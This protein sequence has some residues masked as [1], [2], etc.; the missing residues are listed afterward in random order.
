MLIYKITFP[1]KKVYIGQTIENVSTRISH[2]KT[3]AKLNRDITKYSPAGSKIGNAI[4]KYGLEDDWI[5]IIDT[6]TTLEELNN[7]EIYWIT[8]YSSLDHKNGY[9]TKPGGGNKEH[10]EETKI[11]IGNATK[12]RWQ[13]PEIAER[14]RKGLEKGVQA[15]KEK[16]GEVRVQRVIKNCEL[17]GSPFESRPAEKRK[18]CS[19]TCAAKNASIIAAK[20]K[21]EE[22][23]KENP[24]L[25]LIKNWTIENKEI[26][27]NCPLNKI[28]TNLDPL[29]SLVGV[30]DW[31]SLT[32]ILDTTSRKDF[33]LKLKELVKMYAE[34]DGK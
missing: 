22:N 28:S 31:R 29:L 34:P 18:F 16:K 9:N 24:K 33:L 13:N 32:T 1:N 19:R 8:S 5:E 6:A 10:S 15:M 25:T 27:I 17:C 14:M 26:V 20:K 7:K 4:R 3:D 2:H 21:I 12:D 30:S 11:K 23:K